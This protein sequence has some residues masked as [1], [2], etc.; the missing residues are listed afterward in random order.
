[1]ARIAN[2]DVM[3]D[4]N[5][6][7]HNVGI[8]GERAFREI[9]QAVEAARKSVWVTVA[10]LKG[11]VQMPDGREAPVGLG[12]L[13]ALQVGLIVFAIE[14]RDLPLLQVVTMLTVVAFAVANLVADVLYA[15]LTPRIRLG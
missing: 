5:I 7:V 15:Y 6:K 12:S 8:D 1:M 14:R 11:D 9:C 4:Q 3:M 10:F 2:F 13:G